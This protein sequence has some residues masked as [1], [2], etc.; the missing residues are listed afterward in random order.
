MLIILI[1]G[2]LLGSAKVKI[3]CHG[4]MPDK[5]TR[6]RQVELVRYAFESIATYC[7]AIVR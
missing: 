3:M 6:D 4:G 7:L 2:L 5:A 1:F